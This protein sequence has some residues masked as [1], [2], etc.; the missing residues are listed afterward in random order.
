MNLLRLSH[1]RFVCSVLCLIA[2]SITANSQTESS[3]SAKII[4]AAKSRKPDWK[5]IGAIES[6]YIPLV[7]SEKR[8]LVG[9]WESPKSPSEH[10]LVRVRSV[11][12]LDEAA[13]WLKPVRDKIVADGWRV[14][15]FLTGDEGYLATYEN[16]KRFQIHFRKGTIVADVSADDL[17]RLKEFVQCIVEQI[18]TK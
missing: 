10:A 16:G 14:S 8:V 12:T 15:P 7:P 1:T 6:T 4:E 13:I 17:D 9:A 3:L 11:A 5:F 18:P 2:F